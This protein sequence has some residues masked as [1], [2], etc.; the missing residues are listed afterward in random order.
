MTKEEIRTKWIR[1]TPLMKLDECVDKAMQEYADH[2]TKELQERVEEL[3]KLNSL[4]YHCFKDV[5]IENQ[6][7]KDNVEHLQF[8]LKAADSDYASK[9]KELQENLYKESTR[10]DIL[11]DENV[12]FQAKIEELN[13]KNKELKTHLTQ[14]IECTE[15][16]K[17]ICDNYESENQQLQQR[18]E[19]LQNSLEINDKLSVE[20]TND[21]VKAL[22][23]I[24]EEKKQLQAKIDEL[25]KANEWISV[26][27][28]KPIGGVDLILLVN[29]EV[30]VGYYHAGI[31][32]YYIKVRNED[33][34]DIEIKPNHWKP[35]P[36]APTN[37]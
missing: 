20:A 36:Q 10:A 12:K 1:H 5:V 4:N 3:D 26:E 32:K 35:L 14:Q 33:F 7:L 6:Q 2:Q 18:F 22:N 8:E 19:G 34:E 23:E 17:D 13:L 24:D 21:F 11:Q 29:K 27:E 25:E 9:E 15:H 16:I 30:I 31:K 37:K 28:H